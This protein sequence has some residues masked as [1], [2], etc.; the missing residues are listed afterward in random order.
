M[1]AGS[2]SA[3]PPCRRP[4]GLADRWDLALAVLSV[5][6]L[7]ALAAFRLYQYW[8]Y[9]VDDAFITVRSA[10]NF[11]AGY[12]FVYNRGGPRVEAHSSHLVWMLQVAAAW[13]TGGYALLTTRVAGVLG[14]VACVLCSVGMA[15]DLVRWS[16]AAGG[17]N[18][19]ADTTGVAESH[20]AAP[21]SRLTFGVGASTLVS[22]N[23]L[24]TGAVSGLET[25]L[26][27]GLVAAACWGFTRLAAGS[28]RTRT[29]AVTGVAAGFATW[30]RPEGI[31]WAAGLG[32]FAA[33]VSAA[34]GGTPN[35]MR[36]RRSLGALLIAMVFWGALT[37]FRLAV[38]GRFH[39]NPY[40][41]KLGGPALD[42]IAGGAAYLNGFVVHHLG[43]VLLAGGLAGVVLARGRAARGTAAM[44]LAGAAG[45]LGVTVW[46]GGD[47]IPHLRFVAPVLA[48]LAA[49]TSAAMG[50]TVLR[51]AHGRA[52][53]LSATASLVFAA[54]FL[55]AAQRPNRRA[56]DE[57]QTRVYGWYD[58]HVPLG[59]W[60]GTWNEHRLR[61]GRGPLTVA[62][63]DIGFVGL[64]S[65]AQIIDLAGL[66][67]PAWARLIHD[68][69]GR[70][71]YPTQQLVLAT[72]P[73]V[74]VLTAGALPPQGG[75][76]WMN[77]TVDTIATDSDFREHYQQRAV[78]THKHFPGD[79]Y[80][81]H[82]F[83]RAD[84]LNEPPLAPDPPRPRAWAGWDMPP[85]R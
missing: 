49:L 13:L 23:I 79:G 47:W 55:W 66:A 50:L 43:W 20:A 38:Y 83:L 15:R 33:L 28:G 8:A 70:A 82:V 68:S 1:A 41:A 56:T 19:D 27:A 24:A 73:E 46:E 17:R 12:G 60:L 18:S 81:L 59:K 61:T 9:E 54:L 7:G 77:P 58:A 2:H 36:A 72:R 5:M 48:P 51:L 11:A 44:L 10:H 75:P 42:R 84:V 69:R 78:Y 67:D 32:L 22:T 31:A 74:I 57:I 25:A 39:P 76:R 6:A 37:A 30:S 26:F 65:N 16:V 14:F 80:Y 64:L 35:P 52:L 62:L 3:Q 29:M 45:H 34:G 4:V 85:P 53:R 71:R 40:Y 21:L 63:E